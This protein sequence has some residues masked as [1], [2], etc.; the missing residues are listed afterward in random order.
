[1]DCSLSGSSVHGIL[2]A[3]ILEWV[4]MP[5]SRGSSWLEYQTT[6]SHDSCIAGGFLIH[7]A[8]GEPWHI[9]YINLK[10][11]H[12]H[13][14]VTNYN[15]VHAN[16]CFSHE[17]TCMP[18]VCTLS[19]NKGMPWIQSWWLAILCSSCL[20]YISAFLHLNFS[21][22]Q[23]KSNFLSLYF[24]FYCIVLQHAKRASLENISV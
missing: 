13:Y 23:S 15:I 17:Y 24:H 5:S 4:V 6:V 19:S 7:W 2:Q 9:A 14:V 22:T 10:Y 12:N 8:I 3:R 11:F 18:E 20:T 16:I 21:L 1:M